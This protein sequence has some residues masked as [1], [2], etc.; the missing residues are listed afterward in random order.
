MVKS[1]KVDQHLPPCLLIIVAAIII[2]IYSNT[3]NKKNTPFD[4]S[5][6]TTTMRIIDYMLLSIQI[7]MPIEIEREF[8]WLLLFLLANQVRIFLQVPA[9]E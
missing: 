9:V 1:L 6:L 7:Q 5:P 4:L 2:L 3:S 8:P